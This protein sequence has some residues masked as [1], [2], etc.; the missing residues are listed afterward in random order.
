MRDEN[1]VGPEKTGIGG[2]QTNEARMRCYRVLLHGSFRANEM[3]YCGFYTTREQSAAYSGQAIELAKR[4]AY[5]ELLQTV[6]ASVIHSLMSLEV[7][8]VQE[9]GF[10]NLRK[11][12]TFYR[13][14]CH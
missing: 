14:D 10:A 12:F 5:D 3:G 13:E 1:A 7:E 2:E 9:V 4:A 11:G 8:K 6:A